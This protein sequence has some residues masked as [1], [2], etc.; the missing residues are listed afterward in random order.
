MESEWWHLGGSVIW[1]KLIWAICVLI[2]FKGDFLVNFFR[3]EN[4]EINSGIWM[5]TIGGGQLSDNSWFEFLYFLK[6]QF[7]SSDFDNFKIIFGTGKATFGGGVSFLTKVHFLSFSTTLGHF[8]SYCNMSG[9]QGVRILLT[10]LGH[11]G[12]LS[13]NNYQ[14]DVLWCDVAESC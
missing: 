12:S 13:A 1:Q 8:W 9:C 6:F 10:G 14:P 3:F 4:F 2:E 7:F 5:V 11:W